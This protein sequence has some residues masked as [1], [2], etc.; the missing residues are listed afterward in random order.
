LLPT[1]Q[2]GQVVVLD[3]VSA[4][5]AADI[6]RALEA[7]GGEVLFLPASSPDLTPVEQAFSKITAILRG[8]GERTREA[9]LD[10]VARAVS[11]ITP[12][13]VVGW[14]AHAGYPLPAPSS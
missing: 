5:K 13:D 6:R 9:V 12:E 4:H 8:A 2:P 1:L 3:N 7:R 11:A 14:F 10:A